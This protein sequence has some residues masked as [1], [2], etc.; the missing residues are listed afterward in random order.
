MP[1]E[2]EVVVA[3]H[4][5]MIDRISQC[6]NNRHYGRSHGVSRRRRWKK[7][8]EEERE[9]QTQQGVELYQRISS[10]EGVVPDVEVALLCSYEHLSRCR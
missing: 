4:D 6:L 8:E 5:S 10:R 1:K 9:A 2:L 3:G 7:Q